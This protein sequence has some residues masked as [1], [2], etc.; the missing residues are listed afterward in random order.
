M[1]KEQFNRERN[2]CA[3]AVLADTMLGRGIINETDHAILRRRTLEQ[4]RPVV[5]GLRPAGS[6]Q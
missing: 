5:S 3:A 4:Y 6:T 2:F 1:T